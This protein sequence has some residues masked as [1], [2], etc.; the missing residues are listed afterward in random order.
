MITFLL[1]LGKRRTKYSSLATGVRADHDDLSNIPEKDQR[2]S[3]K[4]PSTAVLVL[5]ECC[6][7][8][9]SVVLGF[10]I[11]RETTPDWLCTSQLYPWCK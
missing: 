7:I 8:L 4:T 11:G 1:L 3:W 6:L 9:L 5:L 10:S 2:E